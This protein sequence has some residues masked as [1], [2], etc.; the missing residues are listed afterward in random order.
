MDKKFY[1]FKFEL[2]EF[3]ILPKI[4][5]YLTCNMINFVFIG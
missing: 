5:L 3:D 1:N 4:I 2:E